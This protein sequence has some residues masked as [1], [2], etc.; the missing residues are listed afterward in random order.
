MLQSAVPADELEA[1]QAKQATLATT[2]GAA[3]LVARIDATNNAMGTGLVIRDINLTISASTLSN[4]TVGSITPT[5]WSVPGNEA[6]AGQPTIITVSGAFGLKLGDNQDSAKIVPVDFTC[7]SNSTLEVTNLGPGDSIGAASA[8]FEV[9]FTYTGTYKVC[10]RLDGGTYVHVGTTA[11]VVYS[12]APNSRSYSGVLQTGS[13]KT[14]TLSGGAGLQLG[15]Q[16][17]AVKV[18]RATDVCAGS[19][20]GGTE[21][22]VDLG[23]DDSIGATT[24]IATF[25]WSEPG[26]YQL[27]YKS[28][29]SGNYTKVPTP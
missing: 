19:A 7:L 22:N 4:N 2:A 24:A 12:T 5:A 13:A 6:Y 9:V 26:S 18:V 27:C 28:A 25:T 15:L 1:V 14:F 17:D 16:Q 8:Q 23:P 11:L 29:S 3:S 10:Y 21:M 20:R